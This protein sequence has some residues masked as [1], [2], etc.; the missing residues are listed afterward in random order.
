[1]I[2]HDTLIHHI[3]EQLAAGGPAAG[4]RGAPV[5]P[6]EPSTARARPWAAEPVHSDAKIR[7]NTGHTWDEWTDLIDAGPGRTAGHTAIAAWVHA[8]HE[9]PGWWAQGVTVGYERIT[10]LR[11]PGQMP[12]GTFSVSRSRVLGL[13][14]DRLRAILLDNLGRTE[15]FPGL[16]TVLRSQP[17]SKALRFAAA[18]GGEPLGSLLFS[19]DPQPEG[20]LRLTVTHDKLTGSAEAGRWKQ[21]WADWLAAVDRAAVVMARDAGQAS[22]P[23]SVPT[24]DSKSSGRA[25]E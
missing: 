15:L 25:R 22:S 5:G 16:D 14:A 23:A 11:L 17:T 20:R 3:R 8:Q 1:M 19:A 2:D 13:S 4:A 21:F 10:G 18:R 9:V 24:A 12:D 6:S 7:E